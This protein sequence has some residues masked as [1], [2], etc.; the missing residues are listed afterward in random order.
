MERNINERIIDSLIV[1]KGE[2]RKRG[3]KKKYGTENV[4]V[5]KQKME[6]KCGNHFQ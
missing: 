4:R 2:H 1:K 6:R 3:K 5:G